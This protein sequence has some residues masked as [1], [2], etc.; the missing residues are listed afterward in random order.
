[1]AETKGKTKLSDDL[2]AL[3]RRI[4]ELESTNDCLRGEVSQQRLIAEQTAIFRKFAE[5]SSQALGMGALDGSIT[6]SNAVLA[7]ILGY[8]NPEDPLGT[9]VSEYYLEEDKK[10]LKAR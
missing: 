1:M 6:W 2:K 7:R 5:T 3:Q 10:F 4:A 8:D 9:N